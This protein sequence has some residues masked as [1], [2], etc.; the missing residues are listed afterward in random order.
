MKLEFAESWLQ[1]LANES[2]GKTR[3]SKA[4]VRAYRTKLDLIVAARNERDLRSIRSL[5][6]KELKGMDGLY[7][8]RV[9]DQFR[10][11]F[12]I[13]HEVSGNVIQVQDLT[14]YH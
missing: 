6:F 9:N 11:V 5:R 1:D 14:D 13:R 8:V 3:F 7:S 12:R 10:I 4:V 2:P